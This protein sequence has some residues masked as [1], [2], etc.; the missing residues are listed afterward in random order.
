LPDNANDNASFRI[1]N[2]KT[3]VTADMLFEYD[4]KQ[5][6]TI[7]VEAYDIYGGIYSRDIEITKGTSSTTIDIPTDVTASATSFEENKKILK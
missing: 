2:G 3:L 6:Y 1:E 4:F 5:S 7:T